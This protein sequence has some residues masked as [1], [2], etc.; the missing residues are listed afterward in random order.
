MASMIVAGR[1]LRIGPAYK[2]DRAAMRRADG[3]T[4]V[5]QPALTRSRISRVISPPSARP[6]VSRIT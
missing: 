4:G 5:Q 1:V 6:L 2:V 3:W